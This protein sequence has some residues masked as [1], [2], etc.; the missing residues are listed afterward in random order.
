MTLTIIII[1]GSK[2]TNKQVCN[3]T[4]LS[5][6]SSKIDVATISHKTDNNWYSTTIT[7]ILLLTGKRVRVSYEVSYNSNLYSTEE[8]PTACLPPLGQLK[9]RCSQGTS[10]QDSLKKTKHST[11]GLKSRAL[12]DRSI[13]IISYLTLSPP[14]C[15]RLVPR[16]KYFWLLICVMFS[17]EKYY[18]LSKRCR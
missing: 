2:M 16:E 13:N 15:S 6:V 5:S 12:E 4:S 17:S 3:S 7:L 9:Q 11:H 1:F 18:N 14:S 8:G 10:A